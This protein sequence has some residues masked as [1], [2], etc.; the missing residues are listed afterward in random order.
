MSVSGRRLAIT[1]IV[2]MGLL[3]FLPVFVW[4]GEYYLVGLSTLLVGWIPFIGTVVP[5]VSWNVAA[6]VTAAICGTGFLLGTHA[7]GRW[8]WTSASRPTAWK[9]GWTV[10]IAGGVLLLFTAGIAV[11]GAIHQITWL[12]RTDEPYL[13]LDRFRDGDY[14]LGHELAARLKERPVQQGDWTLDEVIALTRTQ[15]RERGAHNLRSA[16]LA[17]PDGKV[18]LIIF[19]PYTASR[20]QSL[21]TCIAV[22]RMMAEGFSGLRM[23][24]APMESWGDLVRDAERGESL[25]QYFQADRP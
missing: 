1:I 12:A 20:R 4:N 11:I 24:V 23:T 14:V 8:W 3:F 10:A 18:R 17:G 16:V 21:I 5:Q 15:M 6:L 25:D 19:A 2:V 13:H 9:A 22:P 7:M